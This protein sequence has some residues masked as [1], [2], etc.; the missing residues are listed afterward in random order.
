MSSRDHEL[1]IAMKAWN[2][3]ACEAFKTQLPIM[4]L[5]CL[6]TPLMYQALIS[7]S[8]NYM[9][10]AQIPL[11]SWWMALPYIVQVLLLTPVMGLLSIP[12]VF[13]AAGPMPK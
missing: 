1:D 10:L 2:D 3:N 5:M 11:V 9:A 13:A 4:L 12:L 7:A 6:G 8:T